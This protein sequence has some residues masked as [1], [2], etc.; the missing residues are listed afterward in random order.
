MSKFLIIKANNNNE[1]G[2]DIDFV[3]VELD[4]EIIANILSTKAS[5]S[6]MEAL[7]VSSAMFFTNPI[8]TNVYWRR[9]GYKDEYDANRNIMP[10]IVDGFDIIVVECDDVP[11]LPLGD[12]TV[13]SEQVNWLVFDGKVSFNIDC[14]IKNS[15]DNVWSEEVDVDW[16]LKQ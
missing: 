8:L 5:V 11:G 14:Y 15:P 13:E 6:A 10:F 1:F 9:I 3:A 2:V 7:G 4:D 12:F 16:L